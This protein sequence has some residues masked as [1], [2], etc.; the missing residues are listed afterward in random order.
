MTLFDIHEAFVQ[1]S[2]DASLRVHKIYR[3]Y[4]IYS[5]RL[6]EFKTEKFG[7]KLSDL[8]SV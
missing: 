6:K 4:S 8:F 5:D 3:I 2:K 7:I 1:P